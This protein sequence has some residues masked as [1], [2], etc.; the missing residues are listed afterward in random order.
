[1]F[2]KQSP[3][4]KIRST[5][6]Q[7]GIFEVPQDDGDDTDLEAEL[8]AI[9]SGT[10]SPMKAVFK[11]KLINDADLNKMV[12]NSLRDDHTY[13]DDDDMDDPDLLNELQEITGEEPEEE[14]MVVEN[15]VPSEK[16]NAEII[17]ILEKRIAMY[18]TAEKNS[19]TTGDVAK[20]RRFNRGLKTLTDLLKQ[21]NSGK[22]VNI[23]DIPPEVST[24]LVGAP[25]EEEQSIVTPNRPA[26]PVPKDV[27]FEAT[28]E[29]KDEIIFSPTTSDIPA[30]T[31]IK[32]NSVVKILNERLMEYKK[33]ALKAKKE[34]D[35]E[36]A[37]QFIIV[38][39]QF[40][41]V[42]KMAENG[43]KVDLS[44]MPP[45]PH[46]LKDFLDKMNLAI[47]P[48]VEGPKATPEEKEIIFDNSQTLIEA[49]NERLLTYK[50]VE[51]QAKAEGN[52][53][54]LRRFGRIIKQYED[55]IKLH[56][57]G[58][59]I[60][61]E[62]LPTPPGFGPLP[63]EGSTSLSPSTYPS[64]TTSDNVPNKEISREN[65][66][67]TTVKQKSNVK[68]ELTSRVSG[69]T[70]NLAEKQMQILIDRQ[71]E[72]KLAAIEAKKSGEIEQAKEYLLIFKKFEKLLDVAAIGLPVDLNSLPIPPSQRTNLE[73]SFA[74]INEDDCDPNDNSSD[75]RVRLEEQLAKQL[76]MCK[77]TRD[78]HK[79]MGDVA[80]MN[81]FEN[82]AL[83]VQKDLDF[84]RATKRKN[85]E[86]PKFHYEQKS[87]N[88]IHCNTDLSDNELEICIV[89][90]LNYNVANPKEVDT[91]IKIEFPFP[92]EEPFKSKT[93]V[94]KNTDN[95]DYDQ[96]F[97]IEIQR[98]NRQCQRVFKR[99]SIKLDVYS[100]GGFLRSDV[101]IG[102]VNVKL[103]QLEAKCD[104][105]DSFDIMDGRKVT[106]GKLEVKVR[107][108]NPILTKQIE[109]INEKWLIL[110][111]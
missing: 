91:Y 37:L 21:A 98:T 80:G 71:K 25:T 52:N 79:A 92:P 106:G 10:K 97:K 63:K 11:P 90:G 108:R 85:L 67:I 95:P 54:K 48:E 50:K 38:V 102:T 42:I 99:H 3:S 13:S 22:A 45:P 72:F 74:I 111:D 105:H 70:T 31:P 51:E 84:L 28:S 1:M 12:E 66:D 6:A 60:H 53:G 26:P 18:E 107:C 58:K 81:R 56:N 4:S 86:I 89:R 93:T 78:H 24:R 65:D 30:F 110:S 41:V 27:E 8:M 73:E 87:F 9:T 39:K 14:L 46:Q 36:S 44:D 103:Q 17:S 101:L 94:V 5:N 49:L 76:M 57:A 7:L 61:G 40:D 82:L 32:D 29:P 100:R 75:V 20:S 43:E 33:A 59:P 68:K 64:N 55:A 83:S 69:S 77:N 2:K 104:I 88:I 16:D 23:H 15:D 109:H 47:E 35:K 62:E 19:K 96:K 34:G